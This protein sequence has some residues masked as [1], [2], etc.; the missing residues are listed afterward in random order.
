M[1]DTQTP[2]SPLTPEPLPS[3]PP[4]GYS[5]ASWHAHIAS[6]NASEAAASTEVPSSTGLAAAALPGT[7][8]AGIEFPP[9]TAG[10]LIAI[11]SVDRLAMEAGTPLDPTDEIAAMVYC[12]A[13]GEDA[14]HLTQ[15]GDLG[16]L[17]VAA[18]ELLRPVPLTDLR[19]L[20]EWCQTTIATA[21]GEGEKK[22]ASPA[23]AR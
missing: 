14:F 17:L 21:T 4:M 11:Q 15:G 8:V 22:P 13:L 20:I 3:L 6:M 18:R 19:G 23:T 10:S 1:N 7:M 2:R 9:I 12:M 5:E 16:R